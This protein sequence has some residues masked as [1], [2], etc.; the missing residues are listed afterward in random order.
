MGIHEEKLLALKSELATRVEKI[1]KD[2]HSRETSAKFSEQVTG[3]Q[4]DDVLRNLKNEAQYE[5]EQIEHALVK[6]RNGEYGICEK[7]GA[8]IGEARLNAVPYTTL[9]LGCASLSE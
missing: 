5:L 9:C 3:G 6:M 4:N 1:D 8:D 7:C 2:F